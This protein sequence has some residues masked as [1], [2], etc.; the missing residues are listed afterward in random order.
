MHSPMEAAFSSLLF[1]LALPSTF[2]SLHT[3]AVTEFLGVLSAQCHHAASILM[4]H[5]YVYPS[6]HDG[7]HMETLERSYI[8]LSIR[9]PKCPLP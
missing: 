7:P 3:G 1:H 5:S 9:V 2:C 8:H 6:L 4:Q